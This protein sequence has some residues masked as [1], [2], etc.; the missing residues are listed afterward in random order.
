ARLSRAGAGRPAGER[1]DRRPGRARRPRPHPHGGE[2][3]RQGRAHGVPGTRALRAR[4]AGR[5]P[6]RDRAHAPD[7]RAFPAH[8]ASAGRRPGL[9]ARHAPWPRIRPPGAACDRAFAA[10]SAHRRAHELAF[11][12]AARL[13]AAPGEPATERMSVVVPDWPAPP[14][15]RAFVTTKAEGDMARG[16][17]ARKALPVPAAPRWLRQVHGAAV[18]EA[19]AIGEGAEEPVAD[20]AIARRRGTV[21]SVTVADCMPVLLTDRSGSVVSVAHAGW[22]GLCAGVLEAAAE[23][24]RARELMAWMGPAIGPAV[25]EVGEEVREAFVSRDTGASDAF[26]ASARPGH[27]LLDLYA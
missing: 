15:V 10:A 12:A 17:A 5:V 11:R 22:R 24:M 25:Y 6:A 1:H 27:W 21:C 4:G 23:A 26:R 19:D 8:P 13:Q 3:S 9:Q 20:G 14:N 18:I 7:P 2:P 16:S